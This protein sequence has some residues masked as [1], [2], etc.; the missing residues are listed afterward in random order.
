MRAVHSFPL[1]G[2][3]GPVVGSGLGAYVGSWLT[4]SH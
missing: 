4:T 1:S 2:P 3:L